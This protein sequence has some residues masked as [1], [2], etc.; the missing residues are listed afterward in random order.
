MQEGTISLYL[1]LRKGYRADLEVTAKGALAFA[2]MVRE[3][4]RNIEPGLEVQ[5]DLQS[6]TE[7][8]LY[9]N[10]IVRFVKKA[11]DVDKLSIS[12]LI[13]AAVIALL[14]DVR[15]WGVGEVMNWLKG[16]EAPPVAKTLTEEEVRQ[17]AAKIVTML[18]A[19]VA[20]NER[21]KVFGEL[22]RDATIQGIG[23]SG[24]HDYR[25]S[26]IIR[27]EDFRPQ[28]APPLLMLEPPIPTGHRRSVTRERVTLI[29]PVLMQSDRKWRFQFRG[30]EISA[31][32][33]D[34]DFVDRVLQGQVGVRLKAGIQMD[35]DLEVSEEREGDE[36]H[37]RERRIVH[38]HDIHEAPTLPGLASPSRDEEE[39]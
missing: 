27:R 26:E 13:G 3:L 9:L 34:R 19:G 37:V 31:A 18:N 8:S 35:V 5:L 11:L 38:V 23:A 24:V 30:A 33:R 22:S 21:Q 32:V 14:V 17:V 16:P 7:G 15:S 2:E 1:D 25:P 28:Q 20:L 36:W 4:T 12:T 29:S 39:N 10:I 6:G